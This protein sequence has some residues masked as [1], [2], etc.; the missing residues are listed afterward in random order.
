[1]HANGIT[2]ENGDMNGVLAKGSM[3]DP[4]R[5]TGGMGGDSAREAA[6][7]PEDAFLPL[8]ADSEESTGKPLTSIPIIMQRFASLNAA[9]LCSMLSMQERTFLQVSDEACM[10]AK[11]DCPE[12]GHA[13]CA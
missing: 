8:T 5:C 13:E 1:M 4:K 9:L 10:L 6:S 11:H 3:E 2:N 12:R 7:L